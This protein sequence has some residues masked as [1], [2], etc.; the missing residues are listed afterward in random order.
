MEIWNKLPAEAREYTRRTARKTL[1]DIT[2]ERIAGE[3]TEAD[4][5]LL[6]RAADGQPVDLLALA[7]IYKRVTAALAAQVDVMEAFA[8]Q[9]RAAG[10]P[11]DMPIGEFC[12]RNGIP[13]PKGFPDVLTL[14]P[15]QG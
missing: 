8:D 5:Q 2:A 7:A 11:D 13:F 6:E 15:E 3:F 1:R 10:C 4:F 12:K 9:L 14:P